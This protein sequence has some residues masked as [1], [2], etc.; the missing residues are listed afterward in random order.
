MTGN[1]YEGRSLSSVS[2]D[3]DI[4]ARRIATNGA[5]YSFFSTR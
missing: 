3:G 4:H 1:N 2:S 5:G